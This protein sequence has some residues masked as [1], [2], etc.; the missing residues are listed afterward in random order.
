MGYA[1][2]ADKASYVSTTSSTILFSGEILLISQ[3]IQKTP[4]VF[5]W[6][7]SIPN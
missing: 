3:S 2:L 5:Y 6:Y 4:K 7:E 1:Q